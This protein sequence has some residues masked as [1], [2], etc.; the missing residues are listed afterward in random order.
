MCALPL[1]A[2]LVASGA[3][4]TRYV[5]RPG[6]GPLRRFSALSFALAVPG[7]MGG[8]DKEVPDSMWAAK[9]FDGEKADLIAVV[10]CPCGEEPEVAQLG[11]S[12]CNCGRA[13]IL[14][15]DR[16]LVASERIPEPTDD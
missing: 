14:T 11:T 15:G 7:F 8:F 6:Q 13:F 12:I 9:V 2:R 3:R 10:A 4:R 16:V 1:S 5:D